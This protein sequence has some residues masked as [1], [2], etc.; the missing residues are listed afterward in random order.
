MYESYYRFAKPPFRLVA[1]PSMLFV[2]ASAREGLS[3]LEYTVRDGKGIVVMTGEVGTGKTTL[4]NRF[5][6]QARPSLRTAYIFNPTL[7][8]EQLLR[9]LADELGLGSQATSKVDLARLLYEHLLQE[10]RAGRRTVLFVDE[11]QVLPLETLEELRLLTNL[12]TRHEKLLHIVL[13]GQ[14]ELL[15]T[16]E[17]HALR[18]LRQRVELFIQVEPMSGT[19]TGLYIAHRLRVANPSRPV[20]FTGDACKLIHRC[21]RGVPR[22]INKVCDAALL[23]AFVD[24]TNTVTTKHVREAVRTIDGH[25]VSLRLRGVRSLG[26]WQRLWVGASAVAAACALM[27]AVDTGKHGTSQAGGRATQAAALA[28]GT[29]LQ[30]PAAERILVH[31]ASFRDRAAAETFARRAQLPPGRKLYLQSAATPE[32]GWVRVFLGDFTDAREAGDFARTA[33]EERLFAYATAVRVPASRSRPGGSDEAKSPTPVSVPFRSRPRSPSEDNAFGCSPAS[34]SSSSAGKVDAIMPAMP[35]QVPFL[36]LHSQILP[37]RNDL[38]AAIRRVIDSC[39]FILGRE[40]QDFEEEFAAYCGVDHAIGVDSGTSALLL[41]LRGLGIGPGDEVVLPPNTFIATAESV[42][43]V[44]ATPVFADVDVET[45]QLDPE[46]V[47]AALTPRTRAVI[48]VHLFGRTAP[49]AALLGLTRAR[50]IHLVEDACQAHGARYQGRYVG[51][52]GVAAA[53]SFYPGKNLGAFGDAGAIVTRDAALAE[54]LRQC[55]DHGQRAKYDHV[56]L[57]T[58]ARLDSLQAAVLRVKL[59]HLESWNAARRRVAARYDALLRESECLTP[60]P[61]AVGEDHVHHLYVVRHPRRSA[62]V[63]ALRENGIGFGLHYPVPIHRTAAY[64]GLGLGP[65]SYPNAELLA[66][67]DPFPADVPG[68][69]RHAHR[70]GVRGDDTSRFHERMTETTDHDT[71]FADHSQG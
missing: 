3:R 22:D 7:S 29:G 39:G 12:E 55:R 28:P 16:L 6:D 53:F 10:R 30:A 69:D 5:L 57:G 61:L 36:D 54:T 13:V 47:E 44:G 19:E 15:G 34:S 46:K 43:L 23:V 70:A 62:V 50:G 24:E 45:Q 27:L 25:G 41:I 4:V 32:A 20:T 49:L 33:L 2:S 42:S 58:N 37:L 17:S 60:A 31:L 1:D 71:D 67:G 18:Q 59:P 66:G 26:P 63:H 65:G 40:V 38:D 56:R 51:G 9:A 35:S 14:P 64:A 48:A 52:F 8:G 11:A 21:A 68:A